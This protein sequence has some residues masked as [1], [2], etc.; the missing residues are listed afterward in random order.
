MP[1]ENKFV[2][3]D[4][5]KTR[6][7]ETGSG[8]AELPRPL[9]LMFGKNDR[10]NGSERAALRKEKF[11]QLNLY[12]LDDCKHLVQRDAMEQFDGLAGKFCRTEASSRFDDWNQNTE[13]GQIWRRRICYS[14]LI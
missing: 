13:P 6:C 7:I 14:C 2:E 5:L 9:L 12:I 1:Y 3:V 10:S 8:P 11:P 4:N